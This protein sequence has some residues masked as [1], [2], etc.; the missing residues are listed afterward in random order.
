MA[1]APVTGTLTDLKGGHLANKYPE[2]I[3]TLNAPNAKGGLLHPTEPVIVVPDPVTGLWTAF[4]ESTTDMQDI[5]WYTMQIRWL[6]SGGNYPLS[7][8]PGWALQVPTAG[9]RFSDLLSHPPTNQRM[10]YVDLTAPTAA[11]RRPLTMWLHRDPND[12]ANPLNTSKLY[13]WEE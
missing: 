6:D 10:V 9:G 4:L 13:E 2:I 3:F 12:D 11:Q 1:T 7:D 8:Y 5:A